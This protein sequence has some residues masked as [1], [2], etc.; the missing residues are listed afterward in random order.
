MIFTVTFNPSLDYVVHMDS[1]EPGR[2]NRTRGEQLYPGG[3][4]IN[5]SV[6][7]KNLGLESK[8]LGFLAGQTGR[9]IE[10]LAAKNGCCVDFIPVKSG[11]SRIN[12]KIKADQESEINGQ[13]PQ[14]AP[15]EIN[16]LLERLDAL[17]DG[18]FL[19]LA[20]SIPDTLPSDIY[21]QILKRLKKKI[22]PVVDA[23]G[24]L[25]LGVLKY[26]PFL[27]K[28]NHHEL[29]ALFGRELTLEEIPE[30]AAK[31]QALGARNVLVSMAGDGALLLTED[32][33]RF[34]DRPPKGTV[35]NSVGAGDSMVAGFLYGWITTHDYAQAFRWGLAAGSASAFQDWLANKEEIEKLFHNI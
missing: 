15:E 6:M 33:K 26:R 21:Q 12:V 9:A 11:F 16:L 19:V 8:A 20:G 22:Q 28:P 4:G 2:L 30:Y 13:G 34:Q 25:L 10:E 18:D 1:F 27:V 7:L 3:K 31:L 29:G 23:T 32:G 5:V 14:I 24:E 35:V 17:E